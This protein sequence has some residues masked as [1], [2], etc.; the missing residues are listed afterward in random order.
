M[1]SRST[2]P[3]LVA[4][5]SLK[6]LLALLL[7]FSFLLAVLTSCHHAPLAPE[8]GEI[9]VHF[10]DVGQADCMLLQT[11][12]AVILVDAG[13]DEPGAGDKIVAY[14]RKL[15]IERIDCLA[16]THPHSDHI[17][18][19]AAVLR[20]FSVS[21]CLISSMAADTPLFT[22]LLDALVLEDCR[23]HEAV[24][25]RELVYGDITLEVL[26]PDLLKGEDENAGSAVILAQYGKSRIALT[27]DI[28]SE[29]EK[30]L[31]AHYG[32][33]ALDA[34]LLKVAHHG[35]PTATCADFLEALSPAYAVISC[36]RGNEYGYPSAEVLARLALADVAVLRT[37]LDGTVVL[38][39]DGTEFFPIK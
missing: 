34:D 21:E 31:V 28:P 26:S 2:A 32:K 37:D 6:R 13:S 7:L 1:R 16:L 10:L 17:G 4:V 39:G 24:R 30:K 18:G 12:E 23:M 14:L 11:R 35:S 33:E 29:V 9:L 19:A 27:A 15:G 5:I 8:E 3:C 20:E 25:G 22:E 36:G 38:R